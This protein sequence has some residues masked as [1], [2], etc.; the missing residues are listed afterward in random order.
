MLDTFIHRKN[1]TFNYFF[2]AIRLSMEEQLSAEPDENSDK[3]I[4]RLRIRLPCGDLITRRFL[5]SDHLQTLLNFVASKGFSP[6]DHKLL[7]T[8]PRRDVRSIYIICFLCGTIP[9]YFFKLLLRC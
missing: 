2:Q 3:K 8:Y 1:K 9:G 5:A 4:A 7:T 6:D